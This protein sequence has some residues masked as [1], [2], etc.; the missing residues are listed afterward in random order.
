MIHHRYD[1]RCLRCRQSRPGS[2]VVQC[3][4]C[5]APQHHECWEERSGCA[6]PGCDSQQVKLPGGVD[7]A[8][9]AALAVGYAGVERGVSG[10][11]TPCPICRRGWREQSG[12]RCAGCATLYHQ[13]C[14]D[15]TGGCTVARCRAARRG[16][17]GRTRPRLVVDVG[18]DLCR[19]C[20]ESL[21]RRESVRC[22]DCARPYHRGCWVANQG[23]LRFECRSQRPKTAA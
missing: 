13:A 1:L 17:P 3:A 15:G 2:L 8:S 12:L 19:L 5:S 4:R 16:D 20:T 21:T 9:A 14:W 22:A 10:R 11:V 18:S 23:C 7:G 6:A